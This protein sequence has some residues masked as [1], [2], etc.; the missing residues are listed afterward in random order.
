MPLGSDPRGFF[1]L[2]RYLS[3]LLGIDGGRSAGALG[4]NPLDNVTA[5]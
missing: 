5:K 4:Q 1:R 2:C 3:G